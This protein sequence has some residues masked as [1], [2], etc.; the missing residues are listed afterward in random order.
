MSYTKKNSIIAEYYRQHRDDIVSYAGRRVGDYDVAQDIVQDA[1]LRVLTTDKMVAVTTVGPLVYATV[2]RLTI[3]LWRR[4]NVAAGYERYAAAEGGEVNALDTEHVCSR[5]NVIDIL[6]SGIERLTETKREVYRLAL[7]DSMA[8][9]DIASVLS[10]KYKTAE[11]RL[12][13]ARGKVRDYM[14]KMLA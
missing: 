5:R 14:R 6:E 1:F 2:N 11:S 3:D 10:L 7:Y 8:V 12:C 9:S 4:R 13:I